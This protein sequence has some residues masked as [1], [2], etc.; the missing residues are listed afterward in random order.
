M[1][2]TWL[3]ETGLHEVEIL[4]RKICREII[5]DGVIDYRTGFRKEGSRGKVLNGRSTRSVVIGV[6][7]GGAGIEEGRKDWLS[8]REV[9]LGAG[10]EAVVGIGRPGVVRRVVVSAKRA[11]ERCVEIDDLDTTIGIKEVYVAAR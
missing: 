11:D 1:P 2:N 3:G 9:G 4:V 10:R 7:F 5:V 6:R 8:R